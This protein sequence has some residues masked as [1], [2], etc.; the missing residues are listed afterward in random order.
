M[1]DRISEIEEQAKVILE[2]C[3]QQRLPDEQRDIFEF[4]E[5]GDP[6]WHVH[7]GNPAWCLD[8]LRY[9]LRKQPKTHKATVYW[10]KYPN[11]TVTHKLSPS[12]IDSNLLIGTS[13]VEF[14]EP[15]E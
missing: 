10:Y 7:V 15:Q 4:T 5:K 12:M 2:W 9:R 8:V 1:N 11:G 6:C 3:R 13:T 14:T